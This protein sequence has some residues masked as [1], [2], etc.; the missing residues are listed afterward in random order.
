MARKNYKALQIIRMFGGNRGVADGFV[1]RRFNQGR[2]PIIR[3]SSA[4][5]F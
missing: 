1:A 3:V 5:V 2:E 4:A